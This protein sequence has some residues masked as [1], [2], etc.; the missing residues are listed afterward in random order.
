MD[1]DALADQYGGK[2]EAAQP[3]ATTTPAVDYDALA[4][5][6][7]GKDYVAPKPVDYDALAAKFGGRDYDPRGGEE[8]PGVPLIH[9]LPEGLN[10]GGEPQTG[11]ESTAALGVPSTTPEELPGVQRLFTGQAY[12]DIVPKPAADSSALERGAYGFGRVLS[13]VASPQSIIEMGGLSALGAAI[14]ALANL[15]PATL[16]RSESNF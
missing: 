5:K 14:P 4:S 7:G 3:V 13:R 2:D 16:P 10:P 1:L 9:A 12:E 6:F 15:P 11:K 8:A